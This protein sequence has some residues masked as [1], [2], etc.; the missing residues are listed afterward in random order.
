MTQ[1]PP[2]PQCKSDYPYQ[3]GAM[4]VCPE[5][6]HEWS[7]ESDDGANETTLVRDS[8]GA[9]LQDGDSVTVIKD[10]KYRGGVIK[11]GTKVKSIRLIPDAADG[12]DI[13]CRISGLGQMGIRSKFVKKV[14]E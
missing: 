14:S 1:T 5:C 4:M 11:V 7:P 13:D 10:L 12:H 8:N 6:G 2:C 9:I 3:D